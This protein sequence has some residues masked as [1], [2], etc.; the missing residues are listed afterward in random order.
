MKK[1]L[2]ANNIY[3]GKISA[4]FCDYGSIQISITY[5]AADIYFFNAICP[6]ICLIR[7]R[8]M[9]LQNHVTSCYFYLATITSQDRHT[10]GTEEDA[11]KSSD[12]SERDLSE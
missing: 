9:G 6:S 2:G 12:E 11:V 4:D 8:D 3:T 5:K 10:H 1:T 7:H